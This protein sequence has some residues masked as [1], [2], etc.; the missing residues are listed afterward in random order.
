MKR[1]HVQHM[2][3]CNGQGGS[4][5]ATRV[6]GRVGVT[7]AGSCMHARPRFCDTNVG[8]FVKKVVAK[9]AE[10]QAVDETS[11]ESGHITHP[12]HY[13]SSR[14]A[15]DQIHSVRQQAV[16]NGSS[17]ACRREG[18]AEAAERLPEL[19][20]WSH[21]ILHVP[22]VYPARTLA[23]PTSSLFLDKTR[24]WKWQSSRRKGD[25]RL[26]V[27]GLGWWWVDFAQRFTDR[28]IVGAGWYEESL[29]ECTKI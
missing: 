6:L 16:A 29:N 5:R 19:N 28:P 26:E 10:S 4:R 25:R 22:A 27:D 24:C 1:R 9:L 17:Q 7:H 23:L 3:L 12:N 11:T 15:V 21:L 8:S 2:N 18:S 20:M 13:P 14:T